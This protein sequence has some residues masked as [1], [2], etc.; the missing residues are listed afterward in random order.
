MTLL[1]QALVIILDIHMPQMSGLELQHEV[2]A[3]A[4]DARKS[5]AHGN[6]LTL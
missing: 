2:L 3:R 6:A 5:M 4:G 1:G